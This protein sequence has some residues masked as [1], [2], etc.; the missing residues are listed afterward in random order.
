M[1]DVRPGQVW[2]L[3]PGAPKNIQ[4]EYLIE[5]VLERSVTIRYRSV[6]PDDD[7]GIQIVAPVLNW[8]LYDELIPISVFTGHG[9]LV[10][11]PSDV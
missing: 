10:Y 9:W 7:D 5:F 11:D 4:L 2:R 8:H 6:F 1:T 3:R